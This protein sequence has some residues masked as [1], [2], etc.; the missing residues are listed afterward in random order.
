MPVSIERSEEHGALRHR[1]VPT[2]VTFFIVA[3]AVYATA[4]V[5]LALLRHVVMPIVAIV[6]GVYAARFVFRV[7]GRSDRD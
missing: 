1:A 2:V 6:A 5:A 7:T 3:G 4:F